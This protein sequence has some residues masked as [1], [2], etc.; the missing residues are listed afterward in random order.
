MAYTYDITKSKSDKTSSG[1][2]LAC[3]IILCIVELFLSTFLVAHIYDLSSDINEYIFNVGVYYIWTYLSMLIIYY[4]LS[5]FV[6]K[7]NR[8]WFY[9]IGLLFGAGLVLLV[10]FCG[11]NIASMLTLAGILYGTFHAF[12]YASYNVIKQEMVS[13]NSMKKFA[14]MSTVLSKVMNIVAPI[15]L[16]AL[17]EV[18]TYTQ[19]SIYVLIICAIQIAISFGIKSQKPSGSKFD[20]KGYFKK[21][22]ENPE[23][24]KKLK[25]LYC[26]YCIYGFTTVVT[27]LMNICI[28]M[29][30]GSSFS[31]GTITSVFAVVS[32]ILLVLV[33]RF[34]V[35]NKRNW[36]YIISSIL[37]VATCI[38]F[39]AMPN[40]TTL[41][42][43]QAGVSIAGSIYPL[44][45]D[46]YRNATLKEA[47][48]Y[49][50]IAEHHTVIESLLCIFRVIGFGIVILLGAIG[51]QL[52]FNI[53]L[54]IFV[55][56]NTGVLLG[57][58]MFENKYRKSYKSLET[59]KNNDIIVLQ[60]AQNGETHEN[61]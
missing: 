58:M 50:E 24:G 41:M 53:F 37:P 44:I 30:F 48:L 45:A 46:I 55:L 9:R 20:M 38:L 2:L 61:N 40:V 7:T 6:E 35:E 42:I 28:M 13:R 19:V 47:G 49:S 29:Q 25:F 56:S 10:V 60:S 33:S 8:V 43:Y 27:P 3:H 23:V 36:L 59:N 51:S 17:I 16:G 26:I 22:K 32:T 34:T 52:L 14:T 54:V 21:L 11:Q 39:V 5:I 57:L 15:A 18:S 12:Y 1:C 31:L 4:V